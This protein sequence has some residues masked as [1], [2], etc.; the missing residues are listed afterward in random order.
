MG[1]GIARRSPGIV[2]TDCRLT[3]R[4]RSWSCV[5]RRGGAALVVGGAWLA[6]VDDLAG[7]QAAWLLA[8][9]ADAQAG[10][11]SV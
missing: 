3:P 10:G 5:G 6:S 11:E 7:A 4:R 1:C 2:R 9:A 8:L